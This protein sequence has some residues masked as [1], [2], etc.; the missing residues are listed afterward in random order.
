MAAADR[1]CPQTCLALLRGAPP[2]WP[3]FLVR[4]ENRARASRSCGKWTDNT[5]SCLVTISVFFL[6]YKPAFI[7]YMSIG[8]LCFSGEAWLRHVGPRVQGGLLQGAA[9]DRD[10]IQRRPLPLSGGCLQ[11]SRPREGRRTSGQKRLPRLFAL[12]D[13]K[14]KFAPCLKRI[15][16]FFPFADTIT[17]V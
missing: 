16:G 11:R 6:S 8:L 15:R 14:S 9:H 1:P 7:Q 4:E 5:V 10:R 17:L 3:T 13:S 12:S 2:G